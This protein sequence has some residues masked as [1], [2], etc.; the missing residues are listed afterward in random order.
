MGVGD[1]RNKQMSVERPPVCASLFTAIKST[2][3]I[4]EREELGDQLG[5]RGGRGVR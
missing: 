2:D 1:E 5:E 4:A 3:V